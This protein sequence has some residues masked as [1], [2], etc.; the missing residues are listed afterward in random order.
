MGEIGVFRPLQILATCLGP[1][2]WVR[3]R[4]ILGVVG[5]CWL[6]LFQL[7]T[8]PNRVS[9][10][11]QQVRPT[12]LDAVGWC[13]EGLLRPSTYLNS[14]NDPSQQM[15]V[16]PKGKRFTSAIQIVLVLCYVAIA[17]SYACPEKCVCKQLGS[18]GFIVKCKG[19]M[20]VPRGLPVTTLT[21]W[22]Q[23]SLLNFSTFSVNDRLN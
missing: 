23:R 15:G 3:V 1:S 19:I 7:L 13:W 6:F 2:C 16:G 12:L 20:Q 10:N 22:V 9:E 17:T 8:T 18:K 4:V 21:L 5:R 14:F 11:T